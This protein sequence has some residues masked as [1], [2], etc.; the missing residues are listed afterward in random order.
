MI[1]QHTWQRVIQGQKTQTRRLVKTGDQGWIY[2]LGFN[3]KPITY[4]AIIRNIPK[5]RVIC[6]IDKTYAV[7]PGR[8]KP[9]LMVH[10]NH[11]CHGIDIWQAGLGELAAAAAQGYQE[12]RI[13]IIEI[14]REFLQDITEA[15]AIAEGVEHNWLGDD[16]PPEYADEWAN[17]LGGDEDL[18]CFSARDSY[19][20]LWDSIY[21]RPGERW[22]DNP[23]VWV[24]VFEICKGEQ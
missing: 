11:P 2:G 13:R 8:G 14:R 10:W 21:T 18:P 5:E 15:D 23:E 20:T 9:A 6:Q 12:A 17:Y 4:S 19:A 16:C 7:Q 3:G 24:R 1:F 22:Q